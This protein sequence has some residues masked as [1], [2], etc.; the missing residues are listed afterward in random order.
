MFTGFRGA[1]SSIHLASLTALLAVA[2]TAAADPI[3]DATSAINV[4]VESASFNYQIKV[5]GTNHGDPGVAT[6]TPTCFDKPA[7]LFLTLDPS[8]LGFTGLT[9]PIHFQGTPQPGNPTRVVWTAND[10]NINRTVMVSLHNDPPTTL[11]VLN[12]TG[13]ITTDIQSAASPQQESACA[14]VPFTEIAQLRTVGAPGDNIHFDMV[15]GANPHGVVSV[16]ADATQIGLVAWLRVV[17]PASAPTNCGVTIDCDQS[18]EYHC[19]LTPFALDLEYSAN[20]TDH[21]QPNPTTSQP[22]HYRVCAQAHY[23]GV[24]SGAPACSAAPILPSDCS[25]PTNC[26]GTSLCAYSYYSPGEIDIGCDAPYSTTTM[27]VLKRSTNGGPYV[28]V[29]S[30]WSDTVFRSGR[31]DDTSGPW[32]ETYSYEMCSR[33]TQH[34]MPYDN[35][36]APISIDT[37]PSLSYCPAESGNGSHGPG[38]TILPCHKGG[39]HCYSTH[40]N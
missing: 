36:S 10:V 3:A 25:P 11:T 7:G 29:A 40:S 5:D 8:Q 32:G 23:E 34:G 15:L 35:C 4:R 31:L 12:A 16:T 13:T 38:G 30:G 28:E 17:T 39:P 19:D 18:L 20:G 9:V 24:P 21:W 1:K 27:L 22:G 37:T 6:A 33:L 2:R 14:G 26:A